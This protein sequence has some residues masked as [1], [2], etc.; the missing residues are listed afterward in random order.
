LQNGKIAIGDFDGNGKDDIF[1]TNTDGLYMKLSH[2]PPLHAP[3]LNKVKVIISD[4]KIAPLSTTE[5]DYKTSI[6]TAKCDNR[7]R[8]DDKLECKI[9]SS[10]E[11]K[12]SEQF[13]N[14]NFLR[15]GSGVNVETIVSTIIP[16]KIVDQSTGSSIDYDLTKKRVFIICFNECKKW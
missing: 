2:T 9:S 5:A 12:T 6:H 10:Y 15:T 4:Y 11:I 1:C 16:L 7:V 3:Q 13:N 14:T 8:P